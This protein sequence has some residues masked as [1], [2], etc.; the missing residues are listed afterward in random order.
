MTPEKLQTC[1]LKKFER[2]LISEQIG[3]GN[4]VEMG[5]RRFSDNEIVK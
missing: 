1:N 4:I 5:W 3:I 2:D